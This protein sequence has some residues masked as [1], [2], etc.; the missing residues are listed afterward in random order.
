MPQSPYACTYV[1]VHTHT[2]GCVKMLIIS[3]LM[4]RSTP[5]EL[6]AV[7]LEIEPRVLKALFAAIFFLACHH[8]HLASPPGSAELAF[9]GI[10]K[11]LREHGMLGG[12][13]QIHTH[14]PCLHSEDKKNSGPVASTYIYPLRPRV[15]RAAREAAGS[16]DMLSCLWPGV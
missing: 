13:H 7:G 10:L 16:R 11:L 6:D 14:R 8:Y 5:L 4:P 2:H 3:Y 15:R 9:S 12:Y 1:C